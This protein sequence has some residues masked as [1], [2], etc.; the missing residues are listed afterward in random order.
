MDILLLGLT[1]TNFQLLSAQCCPVPSLAYTA[2]EETR[3][4]TARGQGQEDKGEEETTSLADC[5]QGEH[6][7]VTGSPGDSSCL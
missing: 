5:G 3:T 7:S 2:T 1:S 4:R 6:G